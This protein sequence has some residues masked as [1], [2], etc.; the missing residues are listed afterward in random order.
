MALPIT[1]LKM[2][3]VYYVLNSSSSGSSIGLD[4]L[5][6]SFNVNKYGLDSTYCPGSTPDDRLTNLQTSPY[7]LSYFR[8]YDHSVTTT[9]TSTTGILTP[10]SSSIDADSSVNACL[11]SCDQTYYH[12]GLG[13]YPDI[14]D[15]VYS[16]ASGLNP[17]SDGFYKYCGIE[18]WYQ[19]F[20]TGQVRDIGNCTTTT[21]T[22]SAPT[23][24]TTTTSAPTTTTTTTSAPTTTTT[25]TSSLT[26]FEA[27]DGKSSSTDAC[28]RIDNLVYKVNLYHNGSNVY[29][30]L[31][32]FIYTDSGGTINA[33]SG[34]YGFTELVDTYIEV[35][36]SMGF[37]IVTDKQNC[38]SLTTTTTTTSTPTTTTTTTLAYGS[39][40]LG[41]DSSSGNI[42]CSTGTNTYYTLL[43]SYTTLSALIND[44]ANLYSDT[45]GTNAIP[46]WYSDGVTRSEYTVFLNWNNTGNCA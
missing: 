41:Y 44:D 32:D 3:D 43:Q 27:Y 22:T 35:T 1:N 14:G 34:F 10:F 40:E 33:S 11:L 30:E 23:T 20:N 19:I 16:D 17:L 5:C 7:H 6:L 45:S 9:T 28:A 4:N 12:D 46:G 21:T 39:I 13:V 42:A 25:T 15:Y 31:N 36:E 8:N 2:Q 18:N 37:A 26:S 24:T 29:P 38:S